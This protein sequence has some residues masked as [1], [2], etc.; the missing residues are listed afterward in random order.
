[1]Y[2]GRQCKDPPRA[3]KTKVLKEFDQTSNGE[4]TMS[5]NNPFR[6]FAQQFGDSRSEV[7]YFSRFD[8]LYDINIEKYSLLL[9]SQQ[10]WDVPISH[11]FL[12]IR[13]FICF[14][15][16]SQILSEFHGNHFTLLIQ[17]L[18]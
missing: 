8:F 1:M 10:I 2:V 6:C 4:V 5:N 18:A 17:R 14:S 3:W 13:N 7:N 16:L 12:E 11:L 15:K 9:S